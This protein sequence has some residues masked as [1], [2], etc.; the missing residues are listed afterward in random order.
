MFFFTPER[1]KPFKCKT[2]LLFCSPGWELTEM[3]LF[4]YAIKYI[5]VSLKNEHQLLDSQNLIT[6][7]NGDSSKSR[8]SS[9]VKYSYSKFAKSHA[10]ISDNKVSENSPQFFL[11]LFFTRSFKVEWVWCV[12]QEEAERAGCRILFSCLVFFPLS[13]REVCCV[14][15]RLKISLWVI[16][17]CSPKTIWYILRRDNRLPLLFREELD[18]M[19]AA[20][21]LYENDVVFVVE[22][23]ANLLLDFENLKKSYIEPAIQ[24]VSF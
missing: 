20:G 8:N 7:K 4:R 1:N 14:L 11:P 24:W 12:V 10:Y 6:L 22:G 18:E 16:I 15:I 9:P 13:L 3:G 19:V 2:I 23:T 5:N 17:G 21:D